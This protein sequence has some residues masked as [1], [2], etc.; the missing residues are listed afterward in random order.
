M[1]KLLALLACAALGAT[2]AITAVMLAR[3]GGCDRAPPDD[4]EPVP[5]C[6]PGDKECPVVVDPPAP[7]TSLKD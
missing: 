2:L 3:E 1:K 7:E 4:D 6:K 5:A